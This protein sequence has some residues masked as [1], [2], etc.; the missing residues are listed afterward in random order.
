MH[1]LI[2]EDE[3][4]IAKLIA[5]YLQLSDYMSTIINDGNQVLNWVNE[6]HTDLILLDLMLPGTPGEK[7]CMGLRAQ[8]FLKPIIII[9]AKVDEENRILGLELGADDYLCKPLSPREVVARVKAALRRHEINSQE[10]QQ[11]QL[12]LDE[13]RLYAELDQ[14]SVMLTSIEF[15]LIRTLSKYPGRIYSREQLMNCLYT[16]HR[17]VHSRTIDAHVKKLRIKFKKLFGN[18]EVIQSV[19]GVG[20][21]YHLPS[22]R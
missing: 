21:R 5:D 16:D 2:V 3:P 12:H 7:I 14:N 8:H 6:N 20:Y 17:I 9:T 15:E 10:P 4:R 11:N 22:D 18:L 13:N 19:Y 1:I